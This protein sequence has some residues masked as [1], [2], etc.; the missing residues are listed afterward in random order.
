M[1]LWF[2]ITKEGTW[3]DDDA[4]E[5]LT[6]GKIYLS[7]TDNLISFDHNIDYYYCGVVTTKQQQQLHID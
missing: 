4:A 5:V 1:T 2:I 6:L 3:Y 7:A